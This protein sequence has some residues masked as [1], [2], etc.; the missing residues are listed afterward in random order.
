LKYRAKLMA[1]KK[2]E[3]AKLSSVYEPPSIRA[4]GH[5]RNN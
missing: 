5:K 1:T 4:V 2:T 3:K